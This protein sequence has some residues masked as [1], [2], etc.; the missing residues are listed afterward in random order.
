MMYT[1]SAGKA[2][3]QISYPDYEYYRDNNHA[4]ADVA[5]TPNS[6]GLNDDFSFEGRDVKVITRPVSG[7]YFAVMGIRPYLGRLF[8]RGDD[9]A[10]TRIGG[11]DLV[12]LEAPGFGPKYR[13][14]GSC[15]AHHHRSYAEGVHGIVLR[16]QRRSFHYL[17]GA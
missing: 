16:S 9:K 1:R 12:L 2:I 4:F 15:K 10:K 3:D 5:A 11:D 8:S 14:Q 13:R 7:N 17:A 6:I